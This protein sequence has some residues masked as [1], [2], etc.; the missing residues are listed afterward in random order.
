[1]LLYWTVISEA[2]RRGYS[3]F[4]FGRSSADS[5]TFT[6]KKNWGAVPVPLPY[7]YLLAP[8]ATL[9]SMSA[10]NPKYHR[11]IE[12]WQKLPLGLTNALGCLVADLRQEHEGHREGHPVI[13]GRRVEAVRERQRDAVERDRVGVV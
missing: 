5:G 11:V 12:T 10:S 9:P 2:I 7:H 6:F 3:Q 13:V 8:G 4:S 1:M